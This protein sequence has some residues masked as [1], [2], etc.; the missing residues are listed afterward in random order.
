[1]PDK[2]TVYRWLAS[3][4]EALKPFQDQYARARVVQADIRF[5][6]IRDIADTPLKGV[7]RTITPGKIIDKETGERG[8]DIVEVVE[9]DMIEHRRLQI[10]ARK[11]IAA[12]LAPKKYGDKLAVVGGAEGDAP[13]ALAVS[14]LTSPES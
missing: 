7:K 12:K 11:W 9:A 6:E 10:D 5:D 4:D 8:P 2:S 3:S 13:V 14:W 1:M